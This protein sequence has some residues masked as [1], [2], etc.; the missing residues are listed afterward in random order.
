MDNEKIFLEKILKND[1]KTILS[2][3][4]GGV[5][6]R[7]QNLEKLNIDTVAKEDVATEYIPPAINFSEI[8]NYIIK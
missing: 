5:F 4:E 2:E 7:L 1:R 3:V 6:Y 8:Y